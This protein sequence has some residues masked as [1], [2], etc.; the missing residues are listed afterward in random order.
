MEIGKA[1]IYTFLDCDCR[2]KTFGLCN[3]FY[4]LCWLN[5]KLCCYNMK[6]NDCNRG[7]R[8]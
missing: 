2:Q 6:N 3:S 4:Y 5:G 1:D 7:Y 8:R